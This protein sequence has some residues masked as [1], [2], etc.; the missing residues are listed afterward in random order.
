MHPGPALDYAL[1]VGGITTENELVA[2][3]HPKQLAFF[4]D[5]AKSKVLLGGRQSGK[6]Y[7]VGLWLIADWQKHPGKAAVYITKTAT[8]AVRRV[9]PIL[10]GICKRF[11]IKVRI[12]NSD[13]TLQFPNGYS[14]WVTG[15]KD[16]GEADKIRGEA[17]GF[18][19]IAIDEPATFADDTLEYL[20]TEC[21]DAT[22]MQTNGDILLCG[23]PGPIPKGFWHSL[24]H[25]E[26]WSRHTFT[27]LDNPFL[28]NA[29][30]YL[31]DFKKRY[32]YTN[33]T[34]KVLREFFAQW[35]LD[36]EALVYLTS[37][38]D[39]VD[40]NG[41]FDLPTNR[42]PDLTTIGL[43]LGYE[44]DPCAFV[45]ASSWMDHSEIYIRRAYT[46]MNLT[47][48]LIAGELR[49]LKRQ[50][51]AHKVLVDAG[52]G[53]K[54]TAMALQQSYGVIVEPTPKGLKRPK[55]DLMRGAIN[56]RRVKVH[57]V[58][59]QELVSEYKTILWDDEKANHH[60]LSD[61]HNAD[62]A[63]QACLPHAQFAIDFE[64]EVNQWEGLDPDKVRAFEEAAEQRPD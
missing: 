8:S 5:L 55:I 28:P 37:L 36:T 39:F 17:S 59:A 45:V 48:D 34:P 2:S 30:Q 26:G 53:G 14:V 43:D 1:E 40:F 32:G 9:W 6:T 4:T 42:P 18:V 7:G 49:K 46:V 22:L 50:Y 10:K 38:Q 54:T 41:F 16:K 15:C 3:M 44:P 25:H 57:L 52:G 27:A 31:E 60:E 29:R 33:T 64:P 56:S 51:A 23:T 63:I 19:K 12:N 21:A 61:D 58:D 20:C 47:P 62:A 11:K 35:V 13:L 24:C